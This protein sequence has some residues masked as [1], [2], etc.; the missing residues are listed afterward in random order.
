MLKAIIG[1]GHITVT[2]G[3]PSTPYINQGSRS[4]GM[5]RWN[6]STTNLEVYDGSSWQQLVGAVPSVDLTATA[7]AAISWAIQKMAEEENYKNLAKGNPAI[8]AA[9][10]N[11]EK[12]KQQLDV[13]II[14][15]KEHNVTTT[16]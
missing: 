12:A 13:T 3:M 2:G 14:L 15:S 16:S 8:Q 6:E 4:A 11:L 7:S 10:E 5:V 9:M 1:T